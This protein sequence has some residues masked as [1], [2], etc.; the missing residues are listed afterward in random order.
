MGEGT[1]A[2]E[3]PT[4]PMW[5][6]SEKPGGRSGSAGGGVVVV[7]GCVLGREGE[8]VTHF[9]SIPRISYSGNMRRGLFTLEVAG[10][11][12]FA[13][14]LRS[15]SPKGGQWGGGDSGVHY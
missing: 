2:G 12:T 9:P 14:I 15:P 13:A 3:T 8:R 10:R 7:V 4:P 11:P 6:K 1:S 5:S